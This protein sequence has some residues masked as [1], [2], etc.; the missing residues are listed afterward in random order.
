MAWCMGTNIA[1]SW[2]A[3]GGGNGES[4]TSESVSVTLAANVFTRV[5]D[6]MITEHSAHPKVV[7]QRPIQ[8]LS[9]QGTTTDD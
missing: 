3:G 7:R 6:S 8:I 2:G 1:T 4:Q 5:S 9:S